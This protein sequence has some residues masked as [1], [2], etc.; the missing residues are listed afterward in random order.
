MLQRNK[1]IKTWFRQDY[2][3]KLGFY[4]FVNTSKNFIDKYEDTI[5]LESISQA[6]VLNQYQI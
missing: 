4:L 3:W 6:G 5:K 1:S 2:K